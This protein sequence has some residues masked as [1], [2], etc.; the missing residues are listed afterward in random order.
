M[1]DSRQTVI[2]LRSFV[3]KELLSRVMIRVRTGADSKAPAPPK[4]IKAMETVRSEVM[5]YRRRLPE[6]VYFMRSFV[7]KTSRRDINSCSEVFCFKGK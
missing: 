2:Q 5:P 4:R 7:K 1:N 3:G 6:S